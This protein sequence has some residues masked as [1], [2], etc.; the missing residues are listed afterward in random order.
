MFFSATYLTRILCALL[1]WSLVSSLSAAHAAADCRHDAQ[2]YPSHT[3]RH[4]LIPADVPKPSKG[5]VFREPV[6]G[7]CMLRLTVHDAEPPVGF[8]RNDYSRRQAF[9]ADSSRIL[10]S[11]KDGAWHLYDG[12]SFK[13]VAPLKG[14]AGAAEPQWDATDPDKLFF[15]PRNGVG[16]Q[17][18][19][20]R[21]SSGSVHTIADFSER[22]KRIWPSAYSV[23][24]RSEGSPSRD[25]RYWAFQVENNQWEGLGFFVY[26]K[27]EDRVIATYD[28]KQ[29]SRPK[30]DHLSMSPSGQFVVVSWNDGPV[31]FD[32]QF[33]M[34]R[35]LAKRGE[36][37]DIAVD[38]NGDDVYISVDYEAPGG[39]AYMTNLRTGARTNLFDTYVGG[40]ATALHFSGKA[41]DRPGWAVVS[42]Y[43]DYAGKLKRLKSL[44]ERED[45]IPW[46]NRKVFL[47]QLRPNPRIVNVAFHRSLYASYWTEPHA[48]AN[49]DLSKVIFN[50][51]WGT[52][53]ET[54][55]D[56]Y[57]VLLGKDWSRS[58][59]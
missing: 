9:N 37:S 53:S 51:N 54:D 42:T 3:E 14:I 21:V 25:M 7:S 20:M 50:S 26:D 1:L 31:V 13:Y 32:R 36:H 58:V 46:L 27:V 12:S 19:E 55:V 47:V 2:P 8:A 59:R 56:A 23:Q 43:R 48:S 15:L 41:F 34:P 44:V 29:A 17:L 35:Q 57:V 16:M 5:A 24:T 39:P 38:E 52:A 33:R 10:I 49:R 45:T 4:T 6:F 22:I 18:F 30:P 28:L 11:A 40:I